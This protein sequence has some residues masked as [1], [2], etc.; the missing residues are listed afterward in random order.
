MSNFTKL[1]KEHIFFFI[2]II[3]IA[4][5]CFLVLLLKPH[6]TAPEI[7]DP[8]IGPYNLVTFGLGFD[9]S[10]IL[11]TIAFYLLN[12][13]NKGGRTNTSLLVWSCGFFVYSS[14]FIAHIFRGIGFS[15]ANENS[16]P[17]IFFLWRFG[18]IIWAGC[19]LFGILRILVE[20][21]KTQ[22]IPSLAV[23]GIGFS[24][25]SY[26]LLIVRDIE[27]T[28][29]GFLFGIWI[30]ICFSISYIFFIYGRKSKTTGPKVLFLG[31]LGLTITYMG[32]APWHFPDVIYF[33]FVWYFW[34]LLSLIPILIGFIMFS[35]E[36]EEKSEENLSKIK[37]HD[38]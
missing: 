8:A 23:I 6:A 32:W 7:L 31:Y 3:V 20:D 12:R 30:P 33:Y 2:G 29:Y 18:M 13:W 21:K 17:E 19:S 34:F 26:G 15:W 9:T 4:I 35:K 37:N 36:S 5:L 1:L 25:F 11:L 16:S 38:L 27:W 14:T 28:M 24:W 22:I 10:I